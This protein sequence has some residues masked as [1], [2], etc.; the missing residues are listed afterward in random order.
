MTVI[1]FNNIMKRIQS[2]LMVFALYKI[3]DIHNKAVVNDLTKFRKSRLKAER[4]P[5]NKPQILKKIKHNA[6]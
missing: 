2:V 5:A 4:I 3:P 6:M 1:G